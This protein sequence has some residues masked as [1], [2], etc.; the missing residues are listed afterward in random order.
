MA[1]FFA[2]AAC[3]ADGGT[4]EPDKGGC[5]GDAYTF[6]EVV[7]TPRSERGR[8]LIALPDTLCADLQGGRH[9]PIQSLS[10]YIDPTRNAA[11][12][13]ETGTEAGRPPA[14]RWR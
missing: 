8:P 7:V 14:R 12:P 6:A 13:G 9:A 11:G 4:A 2:P 3:L 1:A 5:G 10:I